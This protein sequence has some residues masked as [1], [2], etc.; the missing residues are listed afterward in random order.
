MSTGKATARYCFGLGA[1]GSAALKG[2]PDRSSSL[3][4]LDKEEAKRLIR[5]MDE[6]GL[7]HSIWTG[8]TPYLIGLCNCD[9]DCLAYR[10]YIEQRG[11]PTFFRAEY[12]C[13]VDPDLCTGC[14]ECMK[15]CQFGAQFYSSASAKVYIDPSRCFGCGVCRAPCPTGAIGLIAREEVPEAAGVWLKNG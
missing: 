7:I 3:E 6:E 9:H 5:E 10:G 15:Q 8:V 4:V 11:V 14:K 1:T 12:V 2:L 13:R